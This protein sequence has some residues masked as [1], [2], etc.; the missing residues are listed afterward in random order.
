[1]SARTSGTIDPTTETAEIKQS[2]SQ[3]VSDP[4]L[5]TLEPHDN[6]QNM[7]RLRRW[8]VVLVIS[9]ASL[10]VACASSVASF[11]ETGAA[12]TFHVSHEVTILGISLFVAGLGAGPLLVGPLSEVYGRNAVYRVSYI[13]FLIFTF[14]VAFAPNIAVFLLFRL[15]T[16]FC[17][18]AFLSVAGGSVSDMFSNTTVANP[19]AVYTMSPFIGPVAGPLISGYNVYW[20]WTYRV[21]ICWIFV[22]CVMLFTF[23]PET[24]VPVILK[25][26][27]SRLRKSTG[28][29]KYYAPLDK[30]EGS[31]A[32][33]V[34]VSCYR[35][36][37]LL[38]FDRMA[39][40]LDT[41]NALL[42]GILYLA[43]QAFPIIFQTKHN[44]N[45]EMTGLTFLGKTLI[46]AQASFTSRLF[47]R[48]AAKF[49]GNPPPEVRLIMGQVGG[50]LVPI[51]LFWLAFTTYSHVHWIAPIIA[52]AP[53]GTGI[54][55]SFTA[56]F[57]YLV[58][59]YRP[60]AASAM[61]SN[62]ALRSAFAAAFP[63]FAGAMYDRLGTVGATALLA[64]LT[65]V[66]APLPF[67]FYRVG[68]RLRM[69]SSFA[70]H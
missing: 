23:V 41:W 32:S 37:Q 67:I 51:S 59:A 40:L 44:F 43:F 33:A 26:K 61:A 4:Y 63:L 6:P 46:A 13:L 56:T 25:R 11:T 18:S 8:I 70:V 69:K 16:G 54:Y 14:P 9:S 20:R 48:E 35:P 12:Q 64:G 29:D 31:L 3:D 36:F 42:L 19:M 22:E 39:L 21:E 27:A 15:L 68:A 17:G 66:M 24:Y 10:C 52:S 62:S 58:T 45:I 34:L 28:N 2:P 60:I 7:S 38:L 30:A 49:D 50:V 53:F 47:A 57:T 5:V 65:S 1:M 55:F